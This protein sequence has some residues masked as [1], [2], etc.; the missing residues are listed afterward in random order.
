MGTTNPS[1]E[2][3][4]EIIGDWPEHSQEAAKDT[5]G[6]YGE[7]DE[8]AAE[9]LVWHSNGP[10]KYTIVHKDGP[11]HQFPV[12]HPDFL[13]QYIEYQA[14]PEKFDEIAQYGGSALTRRTEG[15]L[16]A[17][18][19]KEEANFL[20]VNLSHDIITGEKTP[21]EVREAYT[22]IMAESMVGGSPEYMQDLQFNL[23]E[24]DQRDLDE[25]TMTEEIKEEAE[26]RVEGAEND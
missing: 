3:V 6:K 26:E 4:E 13:E 9:R 2:T 18:C 22:M 21:E 17:T 25:E 11:E 10:W 23:P 7:P 16:G 24:G 12:P 15:E 1:K 19:H 5:V 20:S 8:A 14:P